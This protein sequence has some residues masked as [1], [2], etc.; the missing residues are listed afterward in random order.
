MDS[1]RL[2]VTTRPHMIPTKRSNSAP[3]EPWDDTLALGGTTK[4]TS[5]PLIAL[6]FILNRIREL[7]L[8]IDA[9]SA[10]TIW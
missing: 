7:V 5:V 9:L 6:I 3:G 4:E 2:P 1:Q 8:T 10:Q